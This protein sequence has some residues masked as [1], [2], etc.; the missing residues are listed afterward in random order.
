MR[1]RP[2]LFRAGIPERSE[3]LVKES[4]GSRNCLLCLELVPFGQGNVDGSNILQFS[5]ALWS[6]QLD[7]S[8]GGLGLDDPAETP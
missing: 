7:S 6:L 4:Y 8:L 5:R 2:C 1:P 3:A